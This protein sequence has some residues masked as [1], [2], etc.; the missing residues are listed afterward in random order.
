MTNGWD[1]DKNPTLSLISSN[2]IRGGRSVEEVKIK[3]INGQ[4]L[5]S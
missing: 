1:K 2:L 4:I 3:A 5:I